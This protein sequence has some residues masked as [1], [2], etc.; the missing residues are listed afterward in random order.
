MHNL[1]EIAAHLNTPLPWKDGVPSTGRRGSFHGKTDLFR[2]KTGQLPRKD[3]SS[4]TGRR[5][6]LAFS[7]LLGGTHSVALCWFHRK[8]GQVF[9]LVPCIFGFH[10]KT[11]VRCRRCGGFKP[12]CWA[13]DVIVKYEPSRHTRS[14][15]W[16][17]RKDGHPWGSLRLPR[18]DGGKSCTVQTQGYGA[19]WSGN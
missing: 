9:R 12:P 2:K 11:V 1:T 8:T 7:L 10:R 5:A 4:S 18:K 16:L 17:P 6:A 14:E 13:M 3:G 19:F 15:H